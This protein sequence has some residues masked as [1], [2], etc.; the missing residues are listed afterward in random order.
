M[1]DDYFGRFAEAYEAGQLV[2]GSTI[3][4]TVHTSTPEQHVWLD[5]ATRVGQR[6]IWA[7]TLKLRTATLEG[8][9]F[10]EQAFDQAGLR[11]G[12]VVDLLPEGA[13]P[14]DVRYNVI[15]W[16]HRSTRVAAA[17]TRLPRRH[18]RAAQGLDPARVRAPRAARH[19]GRLGPPRARRPC[20]SPR[21]RC[22]VGRAR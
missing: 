18:A 5:R 7:R 16:V 20:E 21:T 4:G 14:M 11:G 6:A 1:P 9:R 8:A 22:A 17:Q 19:S 2:R 12:F 3:R 15:Q 10:W 13:D